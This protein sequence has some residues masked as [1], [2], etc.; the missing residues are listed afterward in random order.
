VMSIPTMD[1]LYAHSRQALTQNILALTARVQRL[2][3]SFEFVTLA[4]AAT[5]WKKHKAFN[6]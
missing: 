3:H 1:F 5:R 4:E 2:G 6:S